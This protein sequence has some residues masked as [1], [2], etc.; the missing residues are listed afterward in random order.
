MALTTVNN[1]DAPMIAFLIDADNINNAQDIAE[2]FTRLNKDYGPVSIR[3]AY[4]SENSLIHL[5]PT[6]R[7]WGIR[8][9]AN[10]FLPKNTTDVA[11]A[12]DAME[13]ACTNPSPNVIAIGSGDSDFAPLVV[14]L[15]ERGTRVVCFT[16]CNAHAPDINAIYYQ[17]VE[18]GRSHIEQCDPMV[19]SILEAVPELK[20]GKWQ[21]LASVASVLRAKK[22]LGRSVGSPTL[23]KRFLGQFELSP[24]KKPHQ[25]RYLLGA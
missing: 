16:R 12:V 17:V 3:R 23:F 2:A 11:L 1:Q 6:L 15:R 10:L 13:L 18:L 25:V 19:G 24:E 21:M 4:G 8:P 14:R 5:G 20:S 22:L 9:F 7:K